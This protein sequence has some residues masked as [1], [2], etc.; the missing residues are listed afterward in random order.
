M[1]QKQPSSLNLL[2]EYSSSSESE[3]EC[4]DSTCA[5]VQN[6]KPKLPLPNEL[7]DKYQ[8]PDQVIDNPELHGGRIRSF[9]HERNSWATLVYIPL[10]R[11]LTNLF[12][13]IQKE[14]NSHCINVESIAEPHLSLSKKSQKPVSREKLETG[15]F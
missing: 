7:L 13:L 4:E 11:N 8:S 14:L 6:Q 3:N 5:K 10:Q 1:A 12:S 15:F 2:L 9:P